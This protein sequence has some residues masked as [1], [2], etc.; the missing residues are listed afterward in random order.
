MYV[1]RE[2]PGATSA[3]T[4][5]QIT[6]LKRKLSSYYHEQCCCYITNV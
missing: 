2:V 3:P 1:L 4:K 6:S 5:N